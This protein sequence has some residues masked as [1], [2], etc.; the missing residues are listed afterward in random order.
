M[1]RWIAI[2]TLCAAFMAGCGDTD[3]MREGA[4][5]AVAATR[6]NMVHWLQPAVPEP[7]VR[8]EEEKRQGM[9][10]GRPPPTPEP[11]QPGLDPLLQDFVPRLESQHSGSFVG[12]AS[13]ILP[14][15]VHSWIARF[16]AFYPNA[17]IRIA[18]PYAGSL[19]MLE[20]IEGDYDFVFVSREL[21]PTDVTSFNQKF[22]YDPLTVPVSGGSYR[23]YGFLD[24]IGFFV[25]IDNPIDRLSFNQIDA[26][27]SST[28]HRGGEAVSTWG[29]LGLPGPWANRPVHP[30][31]I[32]PWNG[33]EEFVRQRVLNY[34]GNRGEWRE[35]IDFS[36]QAF[37][38]AEK[39]ADDPLGIGY[40]GLAYLT[41]G[42][43]VLPLAADE[44]GENPV[45][46]SYEKVAEASYPLSRL[47][48]F[49]ANR[50]P[51][52]ALEPLLDEF[53][54]FILSRQGQQAVLDDAIYLPLRHD[55]VA[56]SLAVLD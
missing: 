2:T 49:N 44:S 37:P 15:L 26:L 47:I 21:K 31:G 14:N 46:P 11:L 23:H 35:D 55:Q 28:R 25:H 19:G 52:A 1:L 43:R 39:V 38:V 34:G 50:S 33:F 9:E 8:T 30:Y 16:N 41:R 22:G 7:A 10:S 42:V 54:R 53:L 29:D 36:H 27:F 51:E 5:E 18:T 48:Y 17:E 6:S 13:D 45:A 4:D 3:Q 24:A 12:G 32:E 56:E 40:T 20:V